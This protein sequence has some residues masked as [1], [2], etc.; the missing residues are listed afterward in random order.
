[1]YIFTMSLFQELAVAALMVIAV[2]TVLVV[3]GVRKLI[4]RHK[5]EVAAREARER[6]RAEA[7][8]R[9]RRRDA[10]AA[11]KEAAERARAERLAAIAA[12][13]ERNLALWIAAYEARWASI[14]NSYGSE[15]YRYAGDIAYWGEDCD[16]GSTYGSVNQRSVIDHLHWRDKE[17]IKRARR[18]ARERK[19]D[20]RRE[21]RARE[22]REHS[23]LYDEEY[24]AERAY[25]ANAYGAEEGNNRFW[26]YRWR[27]D[28]V[29]NEVKELL[30]THTED[31][32]RAIALA[33]QA[34]RDRAAEAARLERLADDAEAAWYLESFGREAQMEA[35]RAAARAEKLE[36]IRRLVGDERAEEYLA[37]AYP[38]LA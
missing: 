2:P 14:M 30:A 18:E 10:V 31:E 26:E 20:E 23:R 21:A 36:Q 35:H 3:W 24:C 37:K 13:H 22:H 34:E 6:A 17:D 27:R 19:S 4:R 29:E 32:A 33:H 1:M 7:E 25:F 16:L 38:E 28:R 15:W 11:E 5:A 9:Q 12:R 8:E